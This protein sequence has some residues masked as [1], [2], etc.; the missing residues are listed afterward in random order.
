MKKMKIL[1][2]II[3]VGALLTITAETFCQDL[4]DIVCRRCTRLPAGSTLGKCGKCPA[5]VLDS[6]FK[7][8][9]DCSIKLRKCQRCLTGIIPPK[10]TKRPPKPAIAKAIR[11]SEA[12]NG[13]T[14]APAVGQEIIVRLAGNATTGYSWKMASLRGSSVRQVSKLIYAPLPAR[15]AM[16][17][18]GGVYTATFKAL[19]KGKTILIML[20]K[21]GG[22]IG[23]KFTVTID[24]GGKAVP[25]ISKKA[26][27]LAKALKA[28]L[29]KF[30]L[31]IR[32]FGPQDKPFHQLTLRVPLVKDQRMKSW[33][34]SQLNRTAAIKLIDHLA[35]DGFLDRAIE[36][37]EART[38]MPKGPAYTLWVSGARGRTFYEPIGWDSKMLARLDAMSEP[39]LGDPGRK[40]K[41]LLDRLAGLRTK[42]EEQDAKKGAKGK[43]KRKRNA[44]IRGVTP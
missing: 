14:V 16:D 2:L 42:W 7:L 9:K 15:K 11:L 19:R 34:A 1:T 23:E 13:A 37:T 32:Y 39:L 28:D 10:T 31:D 29:A 8:C 30:T 18:V 44:Q 25:P 35:A 26:A 17:G 27:E 3:A 6:K 22:R 38:A 43:P 12:D 5:R 24:V 36:T 41:A 20:Y 33:P 4:G 40:M 21:K